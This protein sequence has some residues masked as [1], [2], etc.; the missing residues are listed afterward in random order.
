[1]KYLFFGAVGK[2]LYDESSFDDMD[3]LDETVL[4]V[5]LNS[6]SVMWK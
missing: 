2:D 4:L 3:N 6:V 5:Q 1:M